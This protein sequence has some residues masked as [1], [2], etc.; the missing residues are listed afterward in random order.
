MG[1]DWIAMKE[2]HNLPHHSIYVS[3]RKKRLVIGPM[4]LVEQKPFLAVDAVPVHIFE[5]IEQ[6]CAELEWAAI[7]HHRAALLINAPQPAT[8]GTILVPPQ[9]IAV[10]VNIAEPQFAITCYYEFLIHSILT[11]KLKIRPFW[12]FGK[13]NHYAAISIVYKNLF[14]HSTQ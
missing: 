12:Q 4:R 9:K 13:V 14:I 5:P 3:N 8:I 11:K 2:Q 6:R 7:E 10:V 1:G